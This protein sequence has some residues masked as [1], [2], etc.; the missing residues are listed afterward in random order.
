MSGETVTSPVVEF[1]VEGDDDA[2]R[3]AAVL[4]ALGYQTRRVLDV[5][6]E[7]K[8]WRT[9]KAIRH[10]RLTSREADVLRLV[11][12][13]RSNDE[14]AAGLEVSRATVKW[15]MHNLLIKMDA[16]NRE[17]IMLKVLG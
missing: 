4:E 12:E 10:Y 1:S 14:I 5:P 7:R 13:G 9:E 2:R 16:R 11:L 15:Y 17:A 3:V 8:K 6:A